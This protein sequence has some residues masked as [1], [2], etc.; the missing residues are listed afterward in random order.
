ME[1]FA[2]A[3]VGGIVLGVLLALG[4]WFLGWTARDTGVADGLEELR[5]IEGGQDTGG[6]RETEAR[7]RAHGGRPTPVRES[8]RHPAR[9]WE[10]GGRR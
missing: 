6:M 1:M 7:H 5:E 10:W 8:E 9:R 3:I 2:T 4:L